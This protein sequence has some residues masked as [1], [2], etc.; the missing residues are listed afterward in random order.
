GTNWKSM[1]DKAKIIRRQ[2]LH[3]KVWATTLKKVAEDLG[4]TSPEV[5]RLCE[6]LNVPRPPQGH[7]QRI[8]L[9]LPVEIIPLPDAGAGAVLEAAIEPKKP[10][11]SKSPTPPDAGSEKSTS[12]PAVSS[13]I[14]QNEIVSPT[15]KSA[16][17]EEKPPVEKPEAVVP[18]RVEFTRKQLYEAIWTTPCQKLAASLGISDV[19][20]AKNCKRLGIPRP[21]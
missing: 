6:T 10:R 4:I 1:S 8:K 20:L 18:E 14:G 13:P 7:W 2:E 11:Q 21:S 12:E 17:T 16:T 3:E 9:G 15:S 19:A 5:S